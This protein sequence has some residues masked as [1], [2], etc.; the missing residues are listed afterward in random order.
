MWRLAVLLL[1][2]ESSGVETQSKAHLPGF[3]SENIGRSMVASGK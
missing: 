1:F 3:S 2:A